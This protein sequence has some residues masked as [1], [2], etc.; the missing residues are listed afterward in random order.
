MAATAKT[1]TASAGPLRAATPAATSVRHPLGGDELMRSPVQF[2]WLNH[3]F[4]EIYF[5][6]DD[7]V[8]GTKAY[9]HAHPW[10]QFNYVSE[11]FMYFKIAGKM[12]VVP[13]SYGIWIP[14]EVEHS[15]HNATAATFRPIHLST[16]LS[17]Q[18]PVSACALHVTPILRSIIDDFA[19]R[20]VSVPVTVQ[21]LRLADV[22]FD[23]LKG[24]TTQ[25]NFLPF[26]TSKELKIVLDRMQENP[27]DNRSLTEWAAYI[28]LTAR[29]LERRC[30][31][32]LG[33][34][35]IEW[36]QRLRFLRAVEALSANKTIQKIAFDLGYST[37]SAFVAMFRRMSGTT[38]KQYH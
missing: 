35:L 13:P 27:G 5:S 24:A 16:R 14:P 9:S 11:G 19:S 15:A 36:R 7:F 1:S 21:D 22:A 38:P 2:P 30:L 4:S 18:L 34:T 29:T 37:P 32:E 28:N 31:S 8:A 23:Q 12:F 20:R 6:T 26:A 33:M 17:E 3:P 10:G 25:D